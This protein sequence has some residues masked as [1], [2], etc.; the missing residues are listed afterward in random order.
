MRLK[1]LAKWLKKVTSRTERQM[2]VRQFRR[3]VRALTNSKRTITHRGQMFIGR[4]DPCPCGN[5]Y[6][7]RMWRDKDGNP[8]L[9]NEGKTQDRPVRF[10]NCCM[11]KHGRQPNDEIM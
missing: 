10:K 4:N 3:Y 7:G 9:N 5:T 2:K 6:V 8:I 11:R 1:K